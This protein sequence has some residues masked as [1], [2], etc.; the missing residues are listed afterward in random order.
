LRRWR[1]DIKSGVFGHHALET[2]TDTLN[3]GEKD[4]TTDSSVT[5]G[6]VTSTDGQGAT[7]EEAGN[8]GV[9]GVFLLAAWGVRSRMGL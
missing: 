9:P 5:H 4:G 8:D 7:G 1:R 2:D 3:D 6:L